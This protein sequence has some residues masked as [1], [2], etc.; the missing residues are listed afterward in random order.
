[1][2]TDHERLEVTVTG[3]VQGVGFRHFTMQTARRLNLH[4]WVRNEPDGSVCLAAEGP[5]ADLEQLLDA[6]RQGPRAARVRHVQAQWR[7]AEHVPG[8][9]GVR[10]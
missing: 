6:V 1:M 4:G 3:R 5:R 8:G 9:F 7:A 2:S 10:R